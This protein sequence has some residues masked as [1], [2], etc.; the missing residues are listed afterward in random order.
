[1]IRQIKLD[2][3]VNM[4]PESRQYLKTSASRDKTAISDKASLNTCSKLLKLQN[5][6]FRDTI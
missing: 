1:M 4:R 5:K 2:Q 3:L 6:A